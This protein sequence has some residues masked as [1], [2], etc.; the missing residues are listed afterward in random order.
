[1]R[2]RILGLFGLLLIVL[3]GWA[4]E[5]QTTEPRTLATRARW[6]LGWLVIESVTAVGW[7]FDRIPP[8]V[9]KAGAEQLFFVGQ[10]ISSK[11]RR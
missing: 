4:S 1:M 2:N 11:G 3:I 8:V 6:V 10:L 5:Q 7:A 9:V